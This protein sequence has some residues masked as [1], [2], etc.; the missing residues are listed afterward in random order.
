MALQLAWEVLADGGTDGRDGRDGR[1]RSPERFW[2]V[3]MEGS[4][5]KEQ[6][7]M[8]WSKWGSLKLGAPRHM[9]GVGRMGE[10]ERGRE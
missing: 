2:E 4:M 5:Q 6:M 1:G 7:W 9:H 3:A 10:S 8:R